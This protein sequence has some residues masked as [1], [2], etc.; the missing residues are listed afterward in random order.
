MLWDRIHFA[1]RALFQLAGS[2]LLFQPVLALHQTGDHHGGNGIAGGVQAGGGR[3]EQEALPHRTAALRCTA[4]A[5]APR[6]SAR[7]V[8]LSG[9]APTL[10]E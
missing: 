8:R 3:I 10:R 1:G 5:E 9:S 7:D 2:D 4:S 6:V